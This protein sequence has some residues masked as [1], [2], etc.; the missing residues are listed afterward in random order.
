MH[1]TP[2][3]ELRDDRHGRPSIMASSRR[4]W[5][6]MTCRSSSE[7]NPRYQHQ[8]RQRRGE[9]ILSHGEYT[10]TNADTG[11]TWEIAVENRGRVVAHMALCNLDRTP[12]RREVTFNRIMRVRN[13]DYD[14]ALGIAR[15]S[16]CLSVREQA[17][18]VVRVYS[19]EQV[20]AKGDVG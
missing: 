13:L 11:S 4:T 7:C 19:R 3:S 2:K 16:Q 15:G 8:R 17:G 9:S 12:E 5:D 18:T 20:T 6:E 1:A 14:F 10:G